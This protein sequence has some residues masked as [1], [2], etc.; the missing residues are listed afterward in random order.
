V[1]HNVLHRIC[2]GSA[3]IQLLLQPFITIISLLFSA[4][5]AVLSSVVPDVT[6]MTRSSV[7]DDRPPEEINVGRK[8]KNWTCLVCQTLRWGETGIGRNLQLSML[9][10]L[11]LNPLPFVFHLVRIFTFS[12]WYTSLL[13]KVC[14]MCIHILQW[15]GYLKFNVNVGADWIQFPSFSILRMVQMWVR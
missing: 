10:F 12:L 8:K 13:I 7:G 2:L 6:D 14:M 3:R 11:Y 4:C 9:T 5:P 1:I 15:S